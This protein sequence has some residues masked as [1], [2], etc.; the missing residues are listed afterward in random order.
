MTRTTRRTWSIT[1]AELVDLLRVVTEDADD[2]ALRAEVA[3]LEQLIRRA[4]SALAQRVGEVDRRRT[5]VDDGHRGARGWVQAVTNCSP[6]DAVARV[7]VGAMM[8]EVPDA[9]RVFVQHLSVGQV[10]ELARLHT[11]PRCGDK[12]AEAAAMLVTEADLLPHADFMQVC[13]R[14]EQLA[15]A[16]GAHRAADAAHAGR[17]ARF[18]ELGA[19][20][21]LRA[22]GGHAQAVTMREILQRYL[23]AEFVADWDACRAEHGAAAAADLCPRTPAQRRFDALHAVFLAAAAHGSACESVDAS[24]GTAD[25]GGTQRVPRV[26]PF[27]PQVDVVVDQHTFE[28]ALIALAGGPGSGRT[29]VG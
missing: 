28:A 21:H 1:G 16:D 23:D 13:R 20:T 29:A 2:E 3:Q 26:K 5:W 22:H 8:R 11:H 14:W 19:E 4:E 7:R 6:A 9:D 10:R 15:D 25:T 18:V 24:V 17:D 12:F 27:S